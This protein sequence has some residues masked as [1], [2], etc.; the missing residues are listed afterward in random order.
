MEKIRRTRIGK[1]AVAIAFAFVIGIIAVK[2]ALADHHH[3]WHH[4]HH[5]GHFHH[6]VAPAPAPL[7]DYYVPPANYYTA[8]EPYYYSEP[9]PPPPGVSLFFGL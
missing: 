1:I 5:W 4:G 8:P 2:P 6:Y 3:G 7:T 9:A